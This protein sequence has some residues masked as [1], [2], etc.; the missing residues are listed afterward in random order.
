MLSVGRNL[1][2]GNPVPVFAHGA[3]HMLFCTNGANDKERCVRLGLVP[4]AAGRR[5]WVVRSSAV[6]NKWS[7][8]IEITSQAKHPDWTWYATGPGGGVVLHDGTIV[9]P[10]NHAVPRARGQKKAAKCTPTQ[11]AV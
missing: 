11:L 3:V 8:P 10:A 1:T 5:I 7:A 6:G 4:A 9:V 2:V